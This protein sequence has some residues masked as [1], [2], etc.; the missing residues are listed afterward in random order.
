MATNNTTSSLSNTM[1]TFYDKVFLERYKTLLRFGIGAYMRKIP[2]NEG[3]TIIFNRMAI[4]TLA[5]TALTEGTT[6]SSIALSTTQVTATIGIY[7]AFTQTSEFYEETSID[8]NLK[9][10]VETMGQHGAETVNQLVRAVMTSFLTTPGSTIQRANGRA[11]DGAILV[12]DVVTGTEIRKAVRTLK[13][14]KALT[15]ED[16]FY[17][18]IIPVES[19]YDL[20]GSTDWI[21]ANTYVNAENWKNGQIGRLHGVIFFET[22]DST[23]TAGGTGSATTNYVPSGTATTVGLSI[24]VGPTVTDIYETF[25]FGK[26]AYGIVEIEGADSG[27]DP[28]VIVKKP[29]S[30]DTSNPLNLYSTIG[31]KVKFA[32]VML[33]SLWSIAI[34]AGATA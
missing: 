33:N 21:S 8:T 2:A 12:T 9:E 20:R 24:T 4:P 5:T 30:S 13:K 3:K 29:N 11:N 32:T 27:K 7:G 26:Q 25:V 18:S 23:V 14:N 17:K 31:W 28:V 6:P 22:N 16:G 10:Q 34:R 19:A 1:S 15:F